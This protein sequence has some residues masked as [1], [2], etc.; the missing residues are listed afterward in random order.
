MHIRDRNKGVIWTPN[1]NN[2][3]EVEM[4][5]IIPRELL[6]WIDERRGKL[7]RQTFMLKCLFKLKE[8]Q[9]MTE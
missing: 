2:W 6:E 3:L 8:I 5:L 7:S 1:F 4:H 9:D